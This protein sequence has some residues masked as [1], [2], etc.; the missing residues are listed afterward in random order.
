MMKADEICN[1]K[2]GSEEENL[3]DKKA[4]KKKSGID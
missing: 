1:G 2:G 3:F 4:K